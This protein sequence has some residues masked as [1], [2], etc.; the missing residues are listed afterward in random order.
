MGDFTFGRVCEKRKC[1]KVRDCCVCTHTCGKEYSKSIKDVGLNHPND[2]SI[3]QSK[4]VPVNK[5]VCVKYKVQVKEEYL[6]QVREADTYSVC[7]IHV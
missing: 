2:Q 6:R 5:Y 3:K 1:V 4:R 7:L